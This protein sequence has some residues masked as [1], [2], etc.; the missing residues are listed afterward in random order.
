MTAKALV[1]L[2]SEPA[3]AHA[4]DLVL[5]GHMLS[6]RCVKRDGECKWEFAR[7]WRDHVVPIVAAR[8]K[9]WQAGMCAEITG[10]IMH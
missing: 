2:T 4:V 3:K 10:V 5:I 8:R 6:A 1:E 7:V 9:I